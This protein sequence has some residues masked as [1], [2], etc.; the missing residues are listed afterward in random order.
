MATYRS[1]KRE[2]AG[3]KFDSDKELRFYREYLEGYQDG[4]VEVHPNYRVAGQYE[5]GGYTCRGRSYKPDFVVLDGK[6]EI[7]HVYDV[8]ASM[9]PK[10]DSKG[11]PKTPAVYINQSMKKSIDDFQRFYRIPVEI[12]VPM[13]GRFRMT[14]LGPTIPLGVFEFDSIDYDITEVIGK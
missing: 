6:G 11:K 1:S 10:I 8:K 3:Y 4:R 5:L 7:I 14:I 12:V 9:T 2:Y 13:K